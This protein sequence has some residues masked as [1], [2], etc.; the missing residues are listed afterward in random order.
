MEI[1]EYLRTYIDGYLLHDLEN[2]AKVATLTDTVGALGYPVVA[3]TL[4]GMEVLGYLLTT[5]PEAFNPNFG[6]RY[7]LNYWDSYL[8]PVYPIY[9]GLGRLFRKLIRNGIAHQFVGKPGVFI[10]K[11]NTTQVDRERKVLYVDALAFYEDFKHSYERQVKPIAD[12]AAKPSPPNI[13]T[14][15]LRLDSMLGVY[16]QEALEEFSNLSN[17]DQ[18]PRFIKTANLITLP[19]SNDSLSSIHAAPTGVL[20]VPPMKDE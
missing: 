16:T 15:Q 1:K 10:G 4:T 13:Q 11:D 8:V 14:M 19:D 2:M 9:D 20:W 5:T 17:Q 7:F 3:T 12:D 18:L 6:Q